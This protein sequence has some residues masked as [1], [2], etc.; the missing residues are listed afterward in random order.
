MLKADAH[1][2]GEGVAQDWSK[3]ARYYRQAAARGH[4]GAQL[5]LPRRLL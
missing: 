3:A 2:G 5:A 1:A 4:A